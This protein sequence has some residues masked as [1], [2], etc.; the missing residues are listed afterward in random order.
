[1]CAGAQTENKRDVRNECTAQKFK[2][3]RLVKPYV[4][5]NEVLKQRHEKTFNFCKETLRALSVQEL[6]KLFNVVSCS[7]LVSERRNSSETDTKMPQSPAAPAPA[8]ASHSYTEPHPAVLSPSDKLMEI[9]DL[10]TRHSQKFDAVWQHVNLQL[11]QR[12]VAL[13]LKPGY[14]HENAETPRPPEP[15]SAEQVVSAVKAALANAKVCRHSFPEVCV[16]T[17]V[18]SH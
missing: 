15:R 3:G 9:V 18:Q 4:E 10:L 12:S 1:M 13:A 11:L 17:S 6:D 14:W 5:Q 8:P 2:L 16:N 7:R